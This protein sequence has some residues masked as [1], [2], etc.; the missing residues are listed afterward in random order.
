M[1]RGHR[2]EV[3][4]LRGAWQE[5]ELE[6]RS[7]YEELRGFVVEYAAE[8]MYV[9]GETRL[10]RGDLVEAGGG[11]RQAHELGR[12]PN[13]GLALVRLA[14]GD[15]GAAA[16]ALQRGPAAERPPTPRARVPP[17]QGPRSLA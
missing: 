9:I 17:A 15:G 2:A 13:P 8:A 6:A 7:A 12:E 1:C 16:A 11:F 5:A 4:R 10:W 14:G 3:I